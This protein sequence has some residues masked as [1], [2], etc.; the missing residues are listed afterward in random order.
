MRFPLEGVRV[1]D[2]T[3]VILGPVCTKLLA[4]LG[5]DVIKVEALEGDPARIS[6]SGV[7][8]TLFLACNFGMPWRLIQSVIS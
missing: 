5:A 7:D 3:Q 1:L 2:F 8:S 4:Q 6:E